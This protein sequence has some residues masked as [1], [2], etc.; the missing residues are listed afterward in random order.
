MLDILKRVIAD[1]N[2]D[3][4]DEPALLKARD[5]ITRAKTHYEMKE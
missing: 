3:I 5:I 4:H 1:D 2:L